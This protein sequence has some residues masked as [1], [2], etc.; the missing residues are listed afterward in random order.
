[1]ERKINQR[2]T[3]ISFWDDYAK[4]YKYFLE[5][6]DFHRESIKT[7]FKMV[8]P[9]WKVLDIGAGDGVLSFPLYSV[10][11]DVVMVE[12]SLGMR[13]LIYEK[14]YKNDICWVN[15]DNRPLEDIPNFE[16]AGY[17][18]IIASH[19]LHLTSMGFKS[20]LEKVFNTGAK[21]IFVVTEIGRGNLGIRWRY[22]D[23]QM[24]FSRTFKIDSSFAYH[25]VEELKEHWH[26][27]SGRKLNQLEISEILSKVV[28]EG[29]HIWLKEKALIGMYWWK[30]YEGSEQ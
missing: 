30:R 10:S 26:C 1:M 28:V 18:L 5:H 8:E 2:S 22:K 15:V 24:F 11:C 4:W 12:P 9:G 20:A 3:K 19:S 25:S 27:L 21:N 23:Y 16:L 29:N 17:D 7:L 13:E 6:N 14:A